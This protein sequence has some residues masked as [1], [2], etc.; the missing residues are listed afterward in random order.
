[1][2]RWEEEGREEEKDLVPDKHVQ[3]RH[4]EDGQVKLGVLKERTKIRKDEFR[5]GVRRR[6]S[7]AEL[8][9]YEYVR[10]QSETSQES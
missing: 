7:Q 1:M 8:Y 3:W 4:R 6:G 2:A 9:L 5:I 10:Y